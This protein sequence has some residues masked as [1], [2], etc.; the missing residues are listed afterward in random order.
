MVNVMLVLVFLMGGQL[1][2]RLRAE[3]VALRAIM[4]TR[5]VLT[6]A[7][8]LPMAWPLMRA[9]MCLWPTSSTSA[10]ARLRWAVVRK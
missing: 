8:T 1:F 10:F 3:S 2:R 6:P 5:L 4:S 7:S 9:V